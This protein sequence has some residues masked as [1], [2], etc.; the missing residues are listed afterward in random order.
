M[1]DD[2]SPPPPR[3]VPSYFWALLAV[4]L[5]LAFVLALRILDP[6]PIL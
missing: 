5:V 4:V 1:N 2:D 3:P 6:A